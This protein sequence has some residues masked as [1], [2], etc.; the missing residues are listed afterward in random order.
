MDRVRGRK[1]SKM[2][3]TR[4]AQGMGTNPSRLFLVS[5]RSTK[6]YTSNLKRHVTPEDLPSSVKSAYMKDK[7]EVLHMAIIN[8]SKMK[9]KHFCKN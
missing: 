3:I 6:W 8:N 7:D 2:V 5:S 4:E 1:F 9:S